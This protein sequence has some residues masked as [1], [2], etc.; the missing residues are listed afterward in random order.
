MISIHLAYSLSVQIFQ[1]PPSIEA[2]VYMASRWNH[3]TYSN[4]PL[5]TRSSIAFTQLYYSDFKAGCC[6]ETVLGSLLLFWRLRMWRSRR[7]YRCRHGFPWWEGYFHST[8]L[9]EFGYQLRLSNENYQT[10]GLVFFFSRLWSTDLLGLRDSTLSRPNWI[11][12]FQKYE[13]S[14]GSS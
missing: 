2:T 4:H 13:Q 5:L 14:H 3:K 9:F 11:I 6:K 12:R 7:A 8:P 10:G 1:L